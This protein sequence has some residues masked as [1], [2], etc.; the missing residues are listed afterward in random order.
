MAAVENVRRRLFVDLVSVVPHPLPE[1]SV[2]HRVPKS[3][4]GE[5]FFQFSKEEIQRS[6]EP[7]RFSIVLKFLR[8]RPSLDAIRAFI[9]KCWNLDGIPVVSNMLHPRNVFIRMT[10]EEDYMKALSREVNDI[11]GIP[12][13]PFHWSPDFKEEEEPSIVPV[14]IV[15]LGLPTNYYHESFLKILTAPIGRFIR[16]DNPTRCATR[17]DGARICVEMDVAKDSLSHFWIEILGLGSS[18]KQEIIYE[19]LPAFCSKCKIQGHNER[20]CRAGKKITGRKVW[21]RQQE[22]VVEE[23]IVEAPKETKNLP[24]VEEKEGEANQD[25]EA[26]LEIG[27][28]SIPLIEELETDKDH[29][30]SPVIEVPAEAANNKEVERNDVRLVCSS[31]SNEVDSSLRE[32]EIVPCTE[33]REVDNLQDE[34]VC[35][36]EG[37]M[38]DPKPKLHAEV[39]LQ[40]KEYHTETEDE[41]GKRKYHKWQFEKIRSSKRVITRAKKL[42]Q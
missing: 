39:F 37:S 30:E 4:D 27:D 18:R 5:S 1:L 38:F 15:L 6:A 25:S 32:V 40:D 10:S 2:A 33:E 11:D 34:E 22:P 17:T 28:S 13:R 14:W 12:Y 36:E 42:S 3:K 20:T 16:R 23:P 9:Q 35:L 7:F 41:V 8:N 26:N 24:V 29:G 21:V 19:T 31:T